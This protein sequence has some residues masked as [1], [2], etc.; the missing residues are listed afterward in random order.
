M[1]LGDYIVIDEKIDTYRFLCS[2]VSTGTGFEAVVDADKQSLFDNLDFLL[3]KPHACSFLRPAG[4]GRIVCTIHE[5]SPFQCKSYRCIIMEIY[6]KDN[7]RIGY[8]TGTMALHSEDKTL[9]SIYENGMK[10][11]PDSTSEKEEWLAQ[12]IAGNGYTIR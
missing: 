3:D 1:Y 7:N 10:T 5:T 6:T 2:S 12:Y 4:D 11:L 8:I 9:R